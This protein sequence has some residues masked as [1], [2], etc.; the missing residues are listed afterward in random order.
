MRRTTRYIA[1]L[2]VVL[3]A[4]LSIA[5][6][7]N[8]AGDP[9]YLLFLQSAKRD[10]FAAHYAQALRAS[11]YGLVY[12]EQDRPIKRALIRTEAAEC[13]AFGSS[14]GMGLSPDN[15][16]P[17]AA[18]CQSFA[19]LGVTL[20]GFE[21]FIALAALLADQQHAK[22][23][24]VVVSPWFFR[25]RANTRWTQIS[26]DVV[27]GAKS[28]D[29]AGFLPALADVAHVKIGAVS[30]A[31]SLYYVPAS[32]ASIWRGAD[33][34][35]KIVELTARDGAPTPGDAITHPDGSHVF[36]PSWVAARHHQAIEE[37]H[38][39]RAAFAPDI[40]K[41][42]DGVIER[43]R[44]RGI[45]VTFVI[46]PYHPQMWLCNQP[47]VCK[48]FADLE[49]EIVALA[50]RRN[51]PVFGSYDPARVGLAADAFIDLNH[52]DPVH[53]DAVAGLLR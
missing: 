31:V 25:A 8:I 52:I 51:V 9:Y 13:A 32:L 3:L 43:L 30:E 29:P 5:A 12:V 36:A 47:S 2:S 34:A 17:A 27:R 44:E 1:V 48:A 10:L 23:L 15:F 38:A 22:R 21:D 18:Q 41:R 19:N 28:L 26:N 16:P 40:V 14:E 37:A 50:R 33:P 7:I 39:D 6:T 11:S 49:S 4:T 20:G 42:W 45:A 53:F 24:F 46:P 35:F